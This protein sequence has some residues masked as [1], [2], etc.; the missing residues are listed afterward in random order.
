MKHNYVKSAHVLHSAYLHVS[1]S[2]LML[3]SC[4]TTVFFAADKLVRYRFTVLATVV[5]PPCL[6]P[7]RVNNVLTVPWL[8]TFQQCVCDHGKLLH[9]L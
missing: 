1:G 5:M 6:K 8:P 2:V 3:K 7:R 9:Q 4:R